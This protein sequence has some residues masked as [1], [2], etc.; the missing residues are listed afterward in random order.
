MAILRCV[1]FLLGSAAV[2]S[3]WGASQEFPDPADYFVSQELSG[4]KPS[5]KLSATLGD[6]MVLQRAPA[7]AVVWGFAAEGTEVTATFKGAMYSSKAGKDGI[8]R[9]HLEPTAAGGGPYAIAFFASTGEEASLVDVLF[10]DVYVCGGQ[11][12]MQFSMQANE[13][14]AAYIKE[15]DSFPDIRLFTVG[16]KT[17]SVVPLVDLQTVLQNWSLASSKSISN[18][19]G[20][21][22]FSA[23][24][25]FFGKGVYKGLGGKVP[26]GLVSSN[27]GGTRDEQWMSPSTSLPCGHNSTGELYNAMIVPFT[28][29]PMAVTGFT[30]YQGESDLGGDPKQPD[31]N[32]NYTCTQAAMIQQWRREFQVPEAFFGVVLL[33]TWH[34][35][36]Q[37]DNILL[38]QLRDQQVASGDSLPNFAYATNADHGAGDNIHPSYKQYPGARLAN[39]ALA[40]VYNQAL[41]WRSPSYA[42]ARATASGEVM[43][44]LEHVTDAGLLLKEAPNARTAGDCVALN[45]QVADTCAW[46]ALQ[47]DDAARSWVNASVAL[48]D[49]KMT[50]L[51]KATLP[52][53]ARSIIAS[54][55][56]WGAIPLMSVY[57]ADLDNQD[58]QLPVLGWNR[59]LV[60]DTAAALRKREDGLVTLVFV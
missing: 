24:C 55:Y 45:R 17:S 56:G 18:G 4:V 43:V 31:S 1:R 8:W 52:A 60:S 33:S 38:A 47:F 13:N 30:W 7:S 39:A 15:A 28:V 6:H 34:P 9:V 27:W 53:G 23:V 50:M 49:D 51:L 12:N 44:W 3:A 10:G 41:T 29:G 14:A 32:N 26:I 5:F 2:N 40:L 11:S 22:Y 19:D 36:T 58:G 20:F 37:A 21:G 42:S 25:W 35:G 54:S 59:P 57:R 16:Q 46:A 48:G